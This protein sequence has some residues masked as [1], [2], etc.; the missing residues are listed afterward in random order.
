MCEQC[1]FCNE[2]SETKLTPKYL[3]NLII[4]YDLN[5]RNLVR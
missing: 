3:W 4:A 5:N 2:L 1:F